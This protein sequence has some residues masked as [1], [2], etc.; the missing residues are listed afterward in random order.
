LQ[1]S[2]DLEQKKPSNMILWLIVDF[3]MLA[4]ALLS[5]GLIIVDEF[6]PSLFFEA[7]YQQYVLH[8]VDWAICGVFFIE[9]VSRMLLQKER[10]NFV[11]RNWYDILGMIPFTHPVLRGFRI[12]RLVRVFGTLIRLKRA[13][14]RLWGDGFAVEMVRKYKSII[15]EVVTDAVV[16]QILN[17]VEEVLQKGNYR[18]SLQDTLNDHRPT[19]Q[20]LVKK[21]LDDSPTLGR[22]SRLPGVGKIQE[23]LITEVSDIVFEFLSDPQFE[24]IIKDVIAAS[25]AT[26]REEVKKLDAQAPQFSRLRRS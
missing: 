13:I 16:L 11:F 26:I 17:I 23:S 5:I 19:V 20:N 21:H 4:L 2:S 10:L 18:K 12:L 6:Y 22:L 15:V 9:F 7:S 25:V 24:N 1:N 3:S 8:R 14:D